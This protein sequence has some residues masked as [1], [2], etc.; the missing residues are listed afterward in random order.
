MSSEKFEKAL[1]AMKKFDKMC[2]SRGI[3]STDWRNLGSFNSKIIE[4]EDGFKVRVDALVNGLI[5]VDGKMINN[6]VY[7]MSFK[8]FY[9]TVVDY[10]KTIPNYS[11]D[12]FN[13]IGVFKCV[14]FALRL[15]FQQLTMKALIH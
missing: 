14:K 10:A 2:E 13:F 1:S 15:M 11:F 9:N 3:K 4:F 5:I 12:F 6:G 7:K 8:Q